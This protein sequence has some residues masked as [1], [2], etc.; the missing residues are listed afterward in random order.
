MILILQMKETEAQR[1]GNLPKVT[2]KLI[3]AFL[4]LATLSLCCILCEL[5]LAAGSGGCS[6][7]RSVG[8]SLQGFSCCAAQAPGHVG[9]GAWAQ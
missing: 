8:F 3:V 1:L 6:S 9:L 4:F 5:S 2:K 7:F